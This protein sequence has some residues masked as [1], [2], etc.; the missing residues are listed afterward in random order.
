VEK[1]IRIGMDTSKSVFQLHGVDSAEQPVLKKKLRRSQVLAFFEK[2]EP[3]MVGLE[4]CGASHHWARGLKALGHDAVLIPPQHVRP[5]VLRGKNDT[6]DAEAICEAMSRPVVRKRFVPMKTVDQQ[7]LGMI[8]KTRAKLIARRTQ[9]A[10]TIRGHAAEFGR[11]APKGLCHI[12]P[13]LG[14]IVESDA[15]PQEAKEIFG[16]LREEYEQVGLHLQKV[17]KALMGFHRQSELSQRLAEVPGI[18]PIGATLLA[19]KVTNPKG[20]RSARDFSAWI[21]LTPKDH[22]TAGKLRHGGIT[23]AGDEAL[24]CVLVQGATAVIQHLKRGNT[25]NVSPWL[26]ALIQRKPEKLVAVALASKTA[27]IAWKLMVS[28]ERYNPNKTRAP[29]G[30]EE[31]REAA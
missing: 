5:Y 29:R 18:G 31:I 24:R 15:V 27:R 13:L 19:A 22:S 23:R 9:L 12:R 17:E 30:R 8:V 16:L 1:L 7:A 25:R 11:I 21:G 3:T 2:L 4:A 6:R 28:G 20:F 10:N 26:M 14:D